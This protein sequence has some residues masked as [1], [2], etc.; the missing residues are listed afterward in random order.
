MFLAPPEYP[1][2]HNSHPS[3]PLSHS[4]IFIFIFNPSPVSALCLAHSPLKNSILAIIPCLEM[5][6]SQ[7]PPWQVGGPCHTSQ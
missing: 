7:P 2:T 6:L 3:K 4:S 1:Q 5:S